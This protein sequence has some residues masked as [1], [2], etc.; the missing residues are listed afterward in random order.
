M[1]VSCPRCDRRSP[2]NARFCARCGL[3]LDPG[4]DGSLAPGHVAHPQCLSVPDGFSRCASAA[5][6]YYRFE[7]AFGGP[8]LLET[9][10][11]ALLIFNAGY[12]LREL[13]FRLRGESRDGQ[14]VLDTRLDLALLERGGCG[15]LEV[16]SWEWSGPA[17]RLTVTLQSARFAIEP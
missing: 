7:S 13:S 10:G 6:L 5:D 15:R 1:D 2:A 9:E 3:S 11:A 16:P 12:P 14:L 4:L 8:L 17:E